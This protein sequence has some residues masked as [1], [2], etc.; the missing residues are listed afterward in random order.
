MLWPLKIYS[1]HDYNFFVLDQS[2]AKNSGE[3][4]T[5][6]LMNGASVWEY[7]ISHLMC[8][9]IKKLNRIKYT[10]HST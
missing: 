1:A 3:H 6:Y 7:F 4:H 5:I 2:C 8:H 9:D 10:V